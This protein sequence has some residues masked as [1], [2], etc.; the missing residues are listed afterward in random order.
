MEI[1]TIASGSKGNCYLINDGEHSLLLECGISMNDILRGVDFKLSSVDA[2]LVTH[3]HGDH[4][5]SVANLLQS[6]VKVYGPAEIL[7]YA[8]IKKNTYNFAAVRPGWKVYLPHWTLRIIE[9]HHDVPCVEY[10]IQSELTEEVV[11]YVTDTCYVMERIANVNYLIAECNYDPDTLQ[12]EMETG[13]LNKE[14][15]DRIIK[16]HL[17]LENLIFMIERN[18]W[19]NSLKEVH[20]IHLSEHNANWERCRHEIEQVVSC[21]VFLPK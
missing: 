10:V 15:R 20:L 16:T 7:E 14:L 21:P 17:G 1:T 12:H 13:I 8:G 4:A 18:E 9:G 6:G 3:E 11:F 19:Q 5:K 2:C